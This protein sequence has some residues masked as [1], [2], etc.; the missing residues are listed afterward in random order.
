MKKGLVQKTMAVL[1]GAAIALPTGT[2]ALAAGASSA[3]AGV[4]T[5]SAAGISG[6][7]AQQV[8]QE[9]KDKGYIKGQADGELHPDDRVTRAELAALVNRSSN[10]TAVSKISF[11]DVSDKA[12]YF[13]DLGKAAAA[14]YMKG[15]GSGGFRPAGQVTRQELAVVLASLSKLESAPDAAAF[16]DTAKSPAWSRGAIGAV[17]KAGLM[18]GSGGLFNPTVAATRA[19]VV[20]VLDRAAKHT[21]A[22]TY[23][24]AGTYGPE[25]GTETVRGSVNVT[26]AGITLRNTVIEGD[27]MLGKDIAEGDVTLDNVTVKGTTKIEGGGPNSIHVIDSVL[28]TVLVDKRTGSVRIVTEG[29]SSVSQITLQSGAFLQEAGTGAGFGNVRLSEL[30]PS[31]STVR[32]AGQF[33][34]LEISA[35]SLNVNLSSGSIG[36]VTVGEG[37]AGT[38]LNVSAA[39]RIARLILNAAATVTGTGT[40]DRAQVNASG[41]SFQ[42]RPQQLT[43]GAGAATPF[44]AAPGPAPVN[45]GSNG[46]GNAGTVPVPVTDRLE[47]SNG[48]AI[49]RFVNPV[50]GLT[51]TDLNVMAT[52]TESAY[53]MPYTLEALDFD[54]ASNKLSFTPLSL[55]EHYGET[56]QVKVTPAAGTTKF[57]AALAGSALIEGFS[58]V[59]TDV[60]NQPVADMRID[61]RRGMGTVDGAIAASVFT[62]ADG[63]YTVYAPAGIYTGVTS[64]NGFISGTVVAVGL[65]DTYSRSENHTAIKIPASDEIRIVLTWGE[66]PRDEDSHLLGPVGGGYG[67]HTWYGEK[68][69]RNNG[70]LIADLDHDDT[71][72]FGPETT[73][74]RKKVDGTYQFYVHNFS[75]NGTG[76]QT[77]RNSGA[78]VDVYVGSQAVPVKSYTIPAGT[79][80]EIYWYAFDMTINGSDIGFVDHNEL[81]NQAPP[82]VYGQTRPNIDGIL[83]TE[84]D[85][86]LDV[87]DVTYRKRNENVPLMIE[88][89]MI[90]EDVA[91]NIKQIREIGVTDEVDTVVGDVYTVTGNVYIGKQGQNILFANY[92]LGT[93]AVVY[94]VSIEL[95]LN[96]HTLDR[97]IEVVVPELDYLLER[98]MSRAAAKLEEQGGESQLQ[99]AYDQA[100]AVLNTEEPNDKIAAYESLIDLLR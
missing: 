20:T 19:E 79:G 88:G 44:I 34:T 40:I 22:V 28:V 86:L 56:L 71:S 21:T 77:L 68:Q 41:T 85:K 90:R 73:T 75:G 31:G 60:D 95:S 98:I 38:N 69:A 49:L 67:F 80:N 66:S 74:I 15:D 91:L 55:D 24:S 12:W 36:E 64:K 32:M 59:V 76:D 70:E 8:M 93:E 27:L 3:H 63:R 13:D 82:S 62:D 23:D 9:W 92:N 72:S 57:S 58:G 53:A 7:W 97:D 25:K 87:T 83:N 84:A 37:A 14:G 47:V 2:G 33:E 29:S 39:A 50:S 17:T 42:T 52:V 1:L 54:A 48:S 94:K 45:G 99:T 26:H 30:I 43:V 18:K 61:F 10:F 81:I 35:A 4:G 65:S 100:E 89:T 6:H 16:S 96:G 78:K 5:K 51:L 11:S 46:S